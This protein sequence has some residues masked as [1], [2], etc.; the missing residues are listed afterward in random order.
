MTDEELISF[1]TEFR[2]GILDGKSSWMMC[3]AVAWPLS[4]LLRM[5]GVDNDLVN[6]DLGECNHFWLRLAD[7]RVLD[8]TADQFNEFGFES[9]PAVYLGSPTKIHPNQPPSSAA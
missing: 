9:M 5:H 3:F 4:G 6:S 2:E 7:G 1:A 8:P